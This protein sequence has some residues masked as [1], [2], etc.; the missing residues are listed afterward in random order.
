[1]AFLNG[2][3][4]PAFARGRGVYMVDAWT[5]Q[6]VW[7]F[8]YPDNPA[9]ADP[10]DPRLQLRYPVPATV[11]M[12]PWGQ[13]AVRREQETNDYFF[14]TASFGDAGGQLWT[15]RFSEPA[16][17]DAGGVSTN[18][19][20]ARAF[21]MGGSGACKLCG[22]QPFFY[23]TANLQLPETGYLRMYAGTG[24]RFN[25][26]DSQSGGQCG[27]DNLRACALRGCTVNLDAPH[28]YTGT[29][30]LGNRSFT[31]SATACGNLTQTQSDG[32]LVT[33]TARGSVRIQ[34][35]CPSPASSTVKHVVAE[36]AND[37]DGEYNCQTTTNIAGSD[38]TLS[39]VTN[40]P[41]LG[42]WYFSLLGFE[43]SGARQIFSTYAGAKSYDGA[44]LFVTQAGAGRPPTPPREIM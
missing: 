30:D 14:D 33:C 41:N 15:L 44:R 34:I 29:T 21:Q 32:A 1:V 40:T 38:L 28:N 37:Q 4:D 36:C 7:D 20:G 31:A 26:L 23:M 16:E 35:S 12:F 3:Y 10:A 17:L 27:P 9:A 18:W 11:G 43:E 5:G 6:L 13:N 24:D 39:D 25:M 22:G 2:G 8:A 19:F 42:N